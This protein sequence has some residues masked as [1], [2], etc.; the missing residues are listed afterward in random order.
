MHL[1]NARLESVKETL[2]IHCKANNRISEEKSQGKQYCTVFGAK[3]TDKMNK[4]VRGA[5]K[6][7]REALQKT[8]V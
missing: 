1:A 4:L 5:G 8:D 3:H 2:Q 7:K 6:L